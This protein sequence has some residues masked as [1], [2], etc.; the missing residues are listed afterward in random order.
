MQEVDR[1]V[2]EHYG[3]IPGEETAAA[4]ETVDKEAEGKAKAAKGLRM[5]EGNRVPEADVTEADDDASDI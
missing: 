1:K 2:R 4:E 3:L 5:V